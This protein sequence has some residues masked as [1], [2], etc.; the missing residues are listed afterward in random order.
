MPLN[1]YL[2][3][4]GEEKICAGCRLFPTKPEA[5]PEHLRRPI[6]MALELAEIE[7][8]GAKFNYP[9]ALSVLEWNILRGL[10]RGRDRAENL[11]Q[12]RERADERRQER[13]R[14]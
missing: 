4:Q 2:G 10:I 7:R 6:Q 9:D 13:K 11:R 12:E 5:V 1:R 14:K 8:G 3:G